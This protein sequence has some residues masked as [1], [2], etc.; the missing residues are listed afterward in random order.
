M[1][2]PSLLHSSR[3]SAE[4]LIVCMRNVPRPPFR[5]PT[6]LQPTSLS[7]YC[8]DP[9]LLLDVSHSVVHRKPQ[10]RLARPVFQ[11]LYLFHSMCWSISNPSEF[12]TSPIWHMQTMNY[13]VTFQLT[14]RFQL[15]LFPSG[16]L[17]PQRATTCSRMLSPPTGMAYLLYIGAASNERSGM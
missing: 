1:P 14:S 4:I 2:R 10:V 17:Q 9:C 7:I 11:I 12:V 16:Q 6:N 13:E 3:R 8:T 5:K 15:Q